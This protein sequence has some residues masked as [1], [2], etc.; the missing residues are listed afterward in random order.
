L[1]LLELPGGSYGGLAMG[2]ILEVEGKRLNHAGDTALFGDMN[3]IGAGGLDL[4]FV[5]IGDNDTMGPDDALQA[6]ELLR[7]K[8]VVPVHHNTFDLLKQDG[9]AFVA[10]AERIGVRGNALKPGSSLEF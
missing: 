8:T 10:Q 6:L 2:V 5:P 3:L 4:A 9:E 7:P 1:A